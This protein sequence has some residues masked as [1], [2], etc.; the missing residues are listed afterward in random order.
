MRAA[1]DAGNYRLRVK[2]IRMARLLSMIGRAMN[3]RLGVTLI[4]VIV[5]VSIIAALLLL[6][7]PAVQSV[8]ENARRTQCQNNIRQQA[9]AVQNYESARRRL[10]SL[11]NGTFLPQPKTAL[12]EFYFH[13]WRT[14]I[15]PRLGESAILNMLDQTLPATD[16][17]NQGAINIDIATFMCPST[18][19]YSHNVSQIGRYNGSDNFATDF[20]GTAA[21]SDYEAVV[22]VEGPT[23]VSSG[24]LPNV[25]FGSW[26]EPEYQTDNWHVR[27]VRVARFVDISDGLSKTLLIAE[28]AGRP[29]VFERN[30]PS[31]PYPFPDVKSA[32]DPHQAAWAISTYIEWIIFSKKPLVNET[33]RSDIYGFHL[34]GASAAFADG[35]VQFLSDS[36]DSAVLAAMA[37]R[38]SGD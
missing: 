8:R 22:G 27:K 4:E 7:L 23:P 32:P 30:K 16:P 34:S 17:A 15:L 11:Y 1:N 10:P 9:L 19:N 6:L 25:R 3:S 33:N 14:P 2:R 24:R 13:S 26:G 28:R 38:A 35:S 37:T 21:R 5:V 18:A 12:D 31:G 29:D 36:T 20:S